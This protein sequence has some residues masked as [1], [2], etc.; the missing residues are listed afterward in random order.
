[1]IETVWIGFSLS[2]AGALLLSLAHIAL[3]EYSKIAL[4]R[5]LEERNTSGRA[6]ILKRFDDI[7]IAV[8][9]W[10]IVFVI[11]V[12]VYVCLAAPGLA[13][14]PLLLFLGAVLVYAVVFDALPRLA[15]KIWKE[16]LLLAVLSA[17]DLLLA[18]TSPILVLSRWL[19]SR[20]ES[21]EEAEEDREAGEEE[22]ETF[23]DE[24]EE[25]G[26]IE[27]DEG[28]LL[29]SVVEFGDT[30]VREIM[31]PRVDMVCIRKDATVQKLR[32]LI[33]TEKFSRVP[34][35]KDR[36]DNIE[37]MVIAKDLLAYSE[38]EFDSAPIEPLIRP[39]V[40][41]PESMKVPDLLGEFQKGMQKIAIV[42]DEHGGVTGMVTMEDV[43]EEIVGEIHDEYDT[44]EAQI[45][46]ISPK[47]FIVS[48]GAKVEEIEDILG[49][50]LSDDDFITVSGMVTYKLGRLP[51]KGET[52]AFDG[53][54]TA[55]IVDVD[56]K[57]IKKVRFRKD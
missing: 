29:R 18:L 26:I 24:A 56:Q 34:V 54:L 27:E 8:E 3:G 21:E 42:V 6:D 15:G 33:I 2:F 57:R 7:R 30:I 23:L 1:M 44:E 51:A 35:Y 41:V 39:V 9:F 36:V 14:Q 31:T 53:G 20:E 32:N 50:E 5:C 45:T 28:E 37:G 11:A 48:G 49:A 19:R 46:R 43:I 47:E 12:F 10:R 38:K 52:L 25:E 22:I 55:E 4:S 13:R 16:K 40:Y 17:R